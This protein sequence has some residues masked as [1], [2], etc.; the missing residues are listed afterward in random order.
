L[1]V[2]PLT[3]ST[4]STH[5]GHELNLGGIGYPGWGP[6]DGEAD[7][8]AMN[9][10]AGIADAQCR[11]N[12]LVVSELRTSAFPS[13]MPG[14]SLHIYDYSLFHMN[15]RNNAIARVAAFQSALT[16]VAA[17]GQQTGSQ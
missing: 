11:N 15:I 9:V 2:N 10:E 14:N 4:N 1:C 8:T 13:R 16:S 12:N 17:D 5:A 7:V 3:W 6:E